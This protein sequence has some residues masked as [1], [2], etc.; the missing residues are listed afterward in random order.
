M[1]AMKFSRPYLPLFLAFVLLFAQQAGAA[2]AVWHAFEDISTHQDKQLP[3]PDACAKC[4][5]YAHLGSAMTASP[6]DFTPPQLS[7]IAEQLYTATFLTTRFLAA[8]ARG[9]PAPLRIYA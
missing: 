6:I 4:A 9:P 8:V 1:P 5:N 2:H 7:G 3:H